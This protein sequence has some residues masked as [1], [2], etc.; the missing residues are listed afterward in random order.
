MRRIVAIA[1]ATLAVAAAMAQ[2]RF[3]ADGLLCTVIDN[4]AVTVA[5]G[6]DSTHFVAGDFTI[7][8]T[9]VHGDSTFNVVGIAPYGFSG[10]YRL[11]ELD[12]PASLRFIGDRAFEGCL[13]LQSIE[14]PDSVEFVGRDILAECNSLRTITLRARRLERFG[15]LGLSSRYGESKVDS[16]MIADGVTVIPSGMASH[17]DA[18]SSVTIP[19]S[20]SS[21]GEG[22]FAFCHS[23]WSIDVAPDNAHYRSAEGILTT[24]GGDTLV[25]WPEAM[26]PDTLLT[27][28]PGIT[29]IAP[30]AFAG[31]ATL[32]GIDLDN[33]TLRLIGRNAFFRSRLLSV[34]IPSTVEEIGPMA[35]AACTRLTHIDVATGNPTYTSRDGV[36]INDRK[37]AIEA[38]PTGR[39]GF[40]ATHGG[41]GSIGIGAFAFC[42]LD[43]IAITEG[44]TE[45]DNAAFSQSPRL[46][47]V[48]LPPSLQRIGKESF[49]NCPRLSEIAFPASLRHIG[50]MAFAFCRALRHIAFA[51]D[52]PPTLDE[53]A[54]YGVTDCSVTAPNEK[55]RD[56]LPDFPLTI[57]QPDNENNN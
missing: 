31:N 39:R 45:I 3:V 35:F 7:P 17:L 50:R 25:A 49:A 2:Q 43:S 18:L 51:A 42:L 46:A 57:T 1:I 6:S 23:L 56:Y 10:C 38:F 19:A 13:G 55:Y 20:V 28:P 22:A 14:I 32:S 12:L 29:S 21:I 40:F 44:V 34:M 47:A 8:A 5:N 16:L 36:L 24:I 4:D 37:Q 53:G 33:G 27:L 54:F 15:S 41:I 30:Q 52:L 9:V 26:L 48:T 11:E